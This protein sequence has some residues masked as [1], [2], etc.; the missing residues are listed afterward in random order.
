VSTR[1]FVNGSFT[2]SPNATCF[3]AVCFLAINFAS[4]AIPSAWCQDNVF[5]MQSKAIGDNQSPIAHWGWQPEN[6]TQWQ[7]H[8]N[9]LIPVYTFGTRGQG[10]GVDLRSYDGENSLYR[11]A[12][13]LTELYGQLPRDTVNPEA[14]YLD[15]TDIYRL[16]KTAAH[17]GKKYIFLF[18]FDGMDWQT[19]QAATTYNLGKVSYE[20]G[21]GR[22]TWFQE[23]TAN[24]TTQYG[25]MVTSPH[26]GGTTVDV[27]EQKVKNPGGTQ[28]GG[29]RVSLGGTSPWSVPASLPYLGG[30][31]DIDGPHHAYTDSASSATSM[32]AG[33]KTYNAAIN[34]D[35]SGQPVDTLAHLLQAEGW[36][37]GAVTSV[38]ISHA[39]PAAAY[40]H[41]VHRS[42]Y[43]DLT[44]DLLGLPSVSHPEKPLSGL[45]V[46]IGTGF[47]SS[48][49]T[50][51]DQGS[52]FVPGNIYLTQADLES[53]H[54]ENG[55]KYV[56]AQRTENQP[57]REGLFA[58]AETAAEKHHRLFGFYG[59][60]ATK[61]L[62]FQTANGDYLPPA[63][64]DKTS[65]TY[66]AADLLEN[67]TIADM[68]AAAIQVLSTNPKGFWLLV[69]PGDVDWA[70]HDNNLDN[71]IGAVN[72]GDEAF[73]VVTQ[74][75]EANS[76]WDE[77]LVIVTADHGH[78]LVI[79]DLDALAKM[80]R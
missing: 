51:D 29:Y 33:I 4:P 25:Y 67:P 46:L 10:V 65:E 50:S 54:V 41:N 74:W 59:V 3:F 12:S 21:R 60:P 66:T 19:T 28:P 56:V 52:N 44:R 13:R 47:G 1:F 34:I 61:H 6:Y 5:R 8:S 57:G 76:N 80:K 26:N 70:N 79:D 63:G 53:I 69:E 37:V 15:Q 9:R 30:K 18:V 55:G 31:T 73:R 42:D 77:T 48:T 23:Y 72:S 7:T 35:P 64:K 49:Q 22:G 27:N 71:S 58:A 11:D 43:Q 62:P 32:T 14:D 17:A 20:S 40:A 36:S 45:D 78:M 24:Q 16:Q 2:Y 39:T 75:V 38:P 68:T